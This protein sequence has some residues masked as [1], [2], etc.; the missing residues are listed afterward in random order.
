MSI[1]SHCRCG[2]S[3]TVDDSFAGKRFRCKECG[4]VETVPPAVAEEAEFEFVDDPLPPATAKK[5]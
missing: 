5:G 4:S 3:Y 2:K 1:R